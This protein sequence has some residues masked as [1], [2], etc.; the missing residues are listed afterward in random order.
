[1]DKQGKHTKIGTRLF[2]GLNYAK[3]QNSDDENRYKKNKSSQKYKKGKNGR[4][5]KS[6]NIYSK[7][8]NN[9][10]DDDSNSDN[11][12]EKVIFFAMDANEDTIDHDEFEEEGEVDLEVELISAL[13]ELHKERKK[14]SLLKKELSRIREDTQNATMSEE[15]KQAYLDLKVHLEEAKIIKESLRKQLEENEEIQELEKEIV[16]FKR[17]LQK[18]TIKQNF[19]KSIEI[20][21]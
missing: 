2:D 10:Y 18:E 4:F 3:N 20:L 21:N 8:N 15:V 17:K 19:D 14:N 9:S 7:E 1:M 13:E 11:D 12:S 6:R 5:A 16:M